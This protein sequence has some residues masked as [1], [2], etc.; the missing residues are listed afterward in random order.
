MKDPIKAIIR[1]LQKDYVYSTQ[2][3]NRKGGLVGLAATAI[4]LM[5]DT[6]LYMNLLIEPILKCFRDQESRVRYYACEAL[7]NVTKVARGKMLE[8]FN[9]IFDGLCQLSAD[10]DVDV[11][12][13]AQLLDRLLKDVV[14]ECE[15]FSA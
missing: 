11:K 2:A 15:T 13:G 10:A 1:Q 8:F 3:N 5:D 14:A 6:A 12:N 4:A 7:Y 9:E